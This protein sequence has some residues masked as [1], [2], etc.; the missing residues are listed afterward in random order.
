MVAKTDGVP[1]FVEELTKMLLESKR[2]REEHDR[3]ELTGPARL[4]SPHAAQDSLMARLD[5]LA[6]VKSLAQL[7]AT[8]GASFP[9]EMLQAS[10]RGTRQPCEG[11][12]PISRRGVPVPAGVAA[13]GYVHRFKLM[14]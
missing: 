3:Y 10:P 12:R 4:A 5:R 6:T 8:L 1:L 11:L 14:P 13:A 2:P 7:G 9:Y